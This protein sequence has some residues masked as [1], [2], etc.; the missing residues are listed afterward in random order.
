MDQQNPNDALDG[1]GDV[2]LKRK[3][4]RPRKYPRP[5][6]EESSYVLFGQNKKLNP[7]SGEQTALPPG[8]EGFNGNQQLQRDQENGSNDAMVGQTVSGL[9]EA[10]FDAGYLLNVRVGDSDTT[11]RGLVFKPGRYVPISPENDVAPGVP[12]IRR[13]E[14]PFPSGTTSQ[15]QNPLVKE[16]NQQHVN[17]HRNESL[18]MNGSPIV[19]QVP[20][21]AVSPINMVASSGNNAPSSAVQ[22]TPQLPSGNMVPVLLQPDNFSSGVPISNQPS[23]V[24]AHIS[25]GSGEIVSKVIPVGGNQTITS[26]TQTSQ[27]ML[28]SSM[29]SEGVPH[30]QP[31]SNVLNGDG[32]NSV[33]PPSLPFE[34]LVTEVV[35][36]VQP[37]SDAMDTETDNINSGDKIPLQDP[38][39]RKED[40]TNDMDQPAPI[41]PLQAVQSHPHENTASVPTFSDYA[42][43][44]K[45]TELLQDN[46]IENQAS[47]TE[48]LGSG[49]KLD[50]VRI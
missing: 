19:P 5:D 22:T 6:S 7:G 12:M 31:S 44:G 37:R 46:N 27:N 33:R 29:P 16:R 18:T 9:I 4:G 15:V 23:Q 30:Y 26:H 21:G 8:Y 40:K 49:N 34:H 24:M 28:P 25:L 13:N 20:R 43:T 48:E 39:I 10:V 45:M 35:N 41:N 14:V 11:L 2:P 36:R 50:D 1:S 42:R 47:K 3:R 38:S 32:A 17:V